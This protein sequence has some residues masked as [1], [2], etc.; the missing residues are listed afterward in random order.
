MTTSATR[1]TTQAKTKSPCDGF[2]TTT[3]QRDFERA[4]VRE[5]A[6]G[7]LPQ[8][9]RERLDDRG[10]PAA[11]QREHDA[12]RQLG[13][14]AQSQL[15]VASRVRSSSLRIDVVSDVARPWCAI[16]VSALER[17]LERTAGTPA[18]WRCTEACSS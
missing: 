3:V 16:G 5:P 7:L 4:E 15:S 12:G 9:E 10:L 13:A 18:T 1:R 8:A 11:Q 14:V 6:R 2:C 17:A